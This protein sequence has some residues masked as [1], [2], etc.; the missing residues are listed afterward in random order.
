MYISCIFFSYHLGTAETEKVSLSI[1]CNQRV[2][3]DRF[4]SH[5]SRPGETARHRQP[6]VRRN[7][8]RC[9]SRFAHTARK[10]VVDSANR[11]AGF[12]YHLPSRLWWLNPFRD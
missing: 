1:H 9:T 11:Y 4:K 8:A 5:G 3:H 12:W 6:L 7:Y 2:V 10:T